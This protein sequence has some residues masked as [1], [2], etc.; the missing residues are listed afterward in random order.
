MALEDFANRS[1]EELNAMEA[2]A[3]KFAQDEVSVFL[4]EDAV[5]DNEADIYI[6][7]FKEIAE[8]GR[9]HREWVRLRKKDGTENGMGVG[10]M[11]SLYQALYGYRRFP[12]PTE[13]KGGIV[14]IEF[15]IDTF[16]PENG[17]EQVRAKVNTYFSPDAKYKHIS[18]LPTQIYADEEADWE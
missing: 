12:R 16:K 3:P 1:E 18:G 7:S 6:L 11:R 9:S 15:K 13:L 4:I 10:H 2:M 5:Y 8:K 17:P 14:S